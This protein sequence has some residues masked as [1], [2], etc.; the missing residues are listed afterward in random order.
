MQRPRGLG[1]RYDGGGGRRLVV[2]DGTVRWFVD[3]SAKF[4]VR[5]WYASWIA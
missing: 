2:L 4:D 1:G 5:S 3:P